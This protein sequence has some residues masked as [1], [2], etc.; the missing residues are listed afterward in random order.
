MKTFEFPKDFV[1]GTAASAYQIEGAWNE[2]GKGISTW[3][4]YVRQPGRVL[5][6]D[7]GDVACNHYHLMA[8]DVALMKEMGIPTY[9]FT[10]SWTRI[11][12]KGRGKVNQ[13]GLDFYD[14]LVDTLLQADIEPKATLY[15][16]DYPQVLQDLGGWHNRESV[17]WF[18]DYA[19]VVFEKLADRVHF[20]ATHN[21]P[22]VQA[23][24]GYGYGLHA[25]GLNDYSQ[26]C[27]AAHHLLLA[28]GETV[29]RF[30]QGGY[31]G[32]IGIVLNLNHL[33]PASDSEEDVLAYQRVYD[34]T[35]SI[36]LDPIYNGTYPERFLEWI[37]AHQ[38]DIQPGDLET[39]NTPTDFIG[40]NHYNSDLV[41][42]DMF[43]GPLKA[44]LTPYSAPGWSQTEMGW[45]INPD[46]LKAEVL[47]VAQ[48]YGN[49]VIYLTENGCAFPDQPDDEGFVADWDRIR[50]I[51]AHIQAL[52]G[53]IQE[54]ADVRGYFVWSFFDNFEWER[55]YSKRFGIVRVDYETLSRIPKQSAYWFRDVVKNNALSV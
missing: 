36:F 40:I 1:W 28:H 49:P 43:S 45:G 12:P 13:K 3:D 16:W 33:A 22:W 21:E 35:H 5:N 7:T 29:R 50:F 42:F 51:S 24:L 32:Q 53:A 47:N 9:S 17:S 18:V 38:P 10:T 41:A 34:E 46:G 44:R 54:G 55:G 14:R 52:H 23:F 26:A 15:H 20:W 39:I 30:K 37:G 4:T 2:D 8:Q 48:N 6:S 31:Q 19:Q 11:L 25:P 27:Q